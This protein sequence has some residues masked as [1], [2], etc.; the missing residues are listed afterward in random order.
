MFR[1]K[2]TLNRKHYAWA[3]L[4]LLALG[5]TVGAAG[6]LYEQFAWLSNAFGMGTTIAL[7]VFTGMRLADAGYSWWLGLGGILAISL[8]MPIA[9]GGFIFVTIGKI[10]LVYIVIATVVISFGSLIGFI[11]WAGTRP[12]FIRDDLLLEVFDDEQDRRRQERIEPS[13]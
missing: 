2:R 9:V 12:S 4:A 3:V 8:L 10:G 13:F 5:I 7:A 11:V 6:E 1:S